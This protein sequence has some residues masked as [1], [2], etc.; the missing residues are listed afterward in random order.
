M[1]A[2]A[3]LHSMKGFSLPKLVLAVWL[4]DVVA[5]TASSTSASSLS[6]SSAITTSGINTISS[7]DAQLTQLPTDPRA[8]YP[9]AETTAT[10]QSSTN[11]TA[12]LF[13]FNQ[14]TTSSSS[15]AVE[16]LLHG[17][18]TVSSL[19][20]MPTSDSAKCNGYVEFCERKYSN[21]TYVVAHNSPF[22]K[23]H[24]AA[25]NQDFDVATQLDNGIR[26]SEYQE[27]VLPYP[28]LIM[29]DRQFKARHTTT[30]MM[31]TSATPAAT[32]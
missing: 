15:V 20:A 4:H 11:A 30:R 10:A 5:D 18:S 22:H 9:S 27:T 25:S 3:Q 24:N 21:V 13:S 14:T 2:C 1:A 6:A 17:S 23:A 12:G 31:S 32:S 7:I 16:T 28:R 29:Y 8:T 26:G 19:T